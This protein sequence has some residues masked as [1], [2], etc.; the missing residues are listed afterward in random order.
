MNSIV[1]NSRRLRKTNAHFA[2]A[3]HSTHNTIRIMGKK[4]KSDRA[5]STKQNGT[6]NVEVGVSETCAASDIAVV[7]GIEPPRGTNSSIS[8]NNSSRDIKK[9]LLKLLQINDY[10]GIMKLESDA[11]RQAKALEGTEPQNASYI[12]IV[13]AKAL[14]EIESSNKVAREKAVRYLEQS[15]A[16]SEK[17]DDNLQD[18]QYVAERLVHFNVKEG[19]HVE[20]FAT[21]KRLASRIPQYELIDPDLILSLADKFSKATQFER[22]I[23]VLTI[24]LGTINRSW[25]KEKRAAAYLAFGQGYTE[26]TEYE[27]AASFLHKALTI[28]DVQ[29]MKV[30]TLG[31]LGSMFTFSCNYDAALSALNQALEILSAESGE[32]SRDKSTKGLSNHATALVH[33][34]I[35]DVLSDQGNHDLEALESFERALVIMK[36]DDIMDAGNLA[37]L[38]HGIGVVHARLGNWDEAIDYLKL[39]H[40]S[41]GTDANVD[42]KFGSQFCEHIGRVRLDQ[43]VWD[44]RL[45]QDTQERV[46]ILLEVLIFSKESMTNYR[47]FSIN[48]ILNC[49]QA[50]YLIADIEHANEFLIKYFEAEMEKKN[51]I[52][53]RSCNRKAGKG[54]DIKICR[55]CQVV[56]YCSEAHQTLAWRRGRLSHKVMCPFLKRYRLVVKAENRIDT[57]P[58][59]DICK[60]FFETVCVLKYEE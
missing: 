45:R 14:E 38:Y 22:V 43:Y 52:Y 10:E 23:D 47:S 24:F 16:L 28:T 51:G 3:T 8:T 48:A 13:I 57:E 49:A 56:D 21:V 32:S 30:S 34:R 5:V 12:Y 58:V 7:G 33:A 46:N 1:V 35:G 39:A 41:I 53:C 55:N 44:E 6:R 50:A 31:V 25:D 59:E 36:E 4:T 19:R 40:S 15:F 29:E 9:S 60:D 37:T 42:S 18:L 20:A 27:K 17:K 2:K 11:I 54:T 26:L